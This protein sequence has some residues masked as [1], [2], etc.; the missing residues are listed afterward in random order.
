[1]KNAILVLSITINVFLIYKIYFFNKK[2][3]DTT[4][5]SHLSI[6]TR[7]EAIQNR[8]ANKLFGSNEN[9]FLQEK[10]L[11]LVRGHYLVNAQGQKIP[12]AQANMEIDSFHAHYPDS[13]YIRSY[14]F[15]SK[16]AKDFYDSGAYFLKVM[17]A[18]AWD[19]VNG[20]VDLN[21]FSLVVAGIDSSGNYITL[22]GPKQG[23]PYVY[24]NVAP[25]PYT[26]GLSGTPMVNVE[27]KN[28]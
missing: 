17:M 25:C 8:I 21:N 19:S 2:N 1:M 6:N 15:S 13:L 5:E 3:S 23:V 14:Y 16:V 20:K 22:N 9:N 27:I 4:E 28:Q 12:V 26:C 24:N 7:N 18:D 11:G 10:P